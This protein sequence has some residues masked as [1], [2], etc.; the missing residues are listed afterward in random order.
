M[1]NSC[2]SLMKLVTT[3]LYNTI[4]FALSEWN[5]SQFSWW[6]LWIFSSYSNSQQQCC[7]ALLQ[8]AKVPTS[9]PANRQL[10]SNTSIPLE[11]LKPNMSH[12]KHL[13]LMLPLMCVCVCASV[14]ACVCTQE[15]MNVHH[16]SIFYCL[17]K[18]IMMTH[19]WRWRE[20]IPSVSYITPLMLSWNKC[21]FVCVCVCVAVQRNFPVR[22]DNFFVTK[23]KKNK[24]H[25]DLK[26]LCCHSMSFPCL[27][28][29]SMP[30]AF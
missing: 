13:Q 18:M 30:A 1:N 9:S 15:C 22:L 29:G 16:S 4:I 14:C 23:A 19:L 17:D 12:F 25:K 8:V 27:Y 6:N 21:V 24:Q 10:H 20:T 28:R 11:W 3:W 5:I 26:P 2:I 7:H